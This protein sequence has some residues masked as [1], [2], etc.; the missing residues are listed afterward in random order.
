MNDLKTLFARTNQSEPGYVFVLIPFRKPFDRIYFSIIKPAIE[1]QGLSCIR[2]DAIYSNKTIM[3]D[4]WEGIQKAEI[5][6][7]DLTDRSP[8]VMYELGLS[9]AIWRKTI[10]IA[11]HLTDVPYDLRSLRVL[12][13]SLNSLDTLSKDLKKAIQSLKALPIED[14]V[15]HTVETVKSE[16][17]FCGN[18]ISNS[19]YN[20]KFWINRVERELILLGPTLRKWLGDSEIRANLITLIKKGIKV[21][22][23][24]S[25]WAP[26][27]AFGGTGVFDLYSSSME[28]IKLKNAIS[29]E[30]RA[31]F[32]EYFHNSVSTLSGVLC[33]PEES[34]GTLVLTPRLAIQHNSENRLFFLIEK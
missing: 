25:D 5:I 16:H 22:V 9:H 3:G 19:D 30:S 17:V 8:N 14:P 28:I 34:N 33:D 29:S 32:R 24:L 1:S 11:Q 31:N 4:V 13:Y 21:N 12:N 10:L 20:W 18:D 7:S 2:G 6:L 23:I 26:I 15:Q 27:E